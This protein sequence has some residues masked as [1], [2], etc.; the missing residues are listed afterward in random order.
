MT[1]HENISSPLATG[2]AGTTF[3]QHVGAMFLGLLLTRGIPPVFRDCQIDEV[4]FQT[5]HLGW[6]TDDLL[7]C[8][9]K[10]NGERH[11]L[12]IQVKRNLVVSSSSPD[13]EQT[14]QGFWDDFRTADLFDPERDA[15][16]LVTL[17]G[18][19]TLLDGLGSL[20][21]CARN[22][23][24]AADFHHKLATP[25]FISDKAR[26]YAEIIRSILDKID[27]LSPFTDGDFWRFL[28]AVYLL[29]C[30]FTTSTALQEASVRNVLAQAATGTNPVKAA[31]ATWHELVGIAAVSAS[32]ART[33]NRSD[34]PESMRDKH[35]T[36]Q[37]PKT[38]L[39]VLREHS[40]FTL[41]GIRSTIAETLTLP[42]NES[43]IRA[44]EALAVVQV[45]VLTGPP[46]SGKS[47]LA[48]AVAQWQA[49]D[50][51]CLSFRAEEFAESHIDNVLKGQ[52]TGT[53]L[54][55]LLAAQE[56]ILI[57]VESLERL[58]EHPTRDA[59]TDLIRMA[60]RCHN[61]RILL[62]CRDYALE[63]AVTS[64]IGQSGLTYRVIDLPPLDDVELSQVV[65][66][67]PELSIPLSN[68]R[69]RQLLRNPYFLDMAAR[70]VWTDAQGMPSDAITFRQRCW[71][72]VVRRDD[73]TTSGLPDRR[74]QAL[75]AL[76][77]RRARELRPSVL[78]EGIDA[79]ALDEL[80]KDGIVSRDVHGLVAPAHDVIED[81]A[82]IHWMESLSATYEWQ[83]SPII[84]AVGGYPALR[85]GFRGWLNEALE[86]DTDKADRF[87]LSVTNDS[88]LPQH[89]RDDVLTCMLLSPLARDFI[90]RQRDQLLANEASLLV[91]LIHLTR[92][93]CKTIP[94]WLSDSGTPPSIFLKPEGEAWSA[95]L[96]AVADGLGG[97]LPAHTGVIV[98]LIEDWSRGASWVEP[99]PAGAEPAG[100][101]AYGLLEQLDGYRYDDLR[102]R[103]LETIARVPRANEKAFISLVERA[104]NKAGR[105][106]PI[107]RAFAE[108]MLYGIDG[109]PACRDFPEQ[110]A[111]LTMS[112]CCLTNA[113]LK[114]MRG[115]YF[116]YIEPAFG[117]PAYLHLRF[118]PAS[119]FRGPFLQLLRHH[120]D[121]GVQLVLDLANHAGRWYGEQKW[122][123]FRLEPAR[124]ITI[125]V[126]G[127]GE[128]NQWANGRLW[129]SYRGTSVTPHVI[130]CALM[131][132]ETWLLELCEGTDD[133][134][135]WL[136]KIVLE[137][138]S[139]M[140][141]AVVA[142]VCNA[143][144]RRSGV[145][146]LALVASRE[147]VEMDR[148]RTVREPPS[149]ILMGISGPDPM[150]RFYT[151]ERK[152]SSALAHRSHDLEA[153]AWKLQLGGKAEQI[154]QIID[155]HRAGIAGENERT[156]ADRAWLLALHRMDMRNFESEV[157]IPSSEDED[158]GNGTDR[159]RTI[160]FKSK[161]IDTDLQGFV[162]A[163]A[164]ERD[165]FFAD[166]R[167]VSWGLQQ[168]E[169]RSDEW[170]PDAWQAALKQAK[171]V[172]SAGVPEAFVGLA[173][174]GLGLVAALYARDH[175]GALGPDDQRW[176]FDT[177]IAEVERDSDTEDSIKQVANDPMK[178]DRHSAY[179][180]PKFISKNPDNAPVLKAIAR[181]ITHACDQ[182]A[183]S[184]AEG[185]GEY[186]VP[187]SEDLMMRGVGALAMQANLLNR[188]NKHRT[189]SNSQSIE[190]QSAYS[191]AVQQV[192][193]QVRDAF[194]AGAINVETELK[195]LDLTSWTGMDA[196]VSIL[197]MLGKAPN[198]S[199]SRDFFV[200]AAQALVASWMTDHEERNSGRDFIRENAVMTRLVAVALALPPDAATYCCGPFLDA[201][202]DHPR[203][204]ATFVDL[205]IAQEERSSSDK[206][207]FWH[208]WQAFA[209]RVLDARWVSS[210]GS[211][212]S[213]GSDL[214]DKLLFRV[215]WKEGIRRWHRLDGHEHKVDGFTTH[216]PVAT[217]ILAAYASY[218]YTIGE[219][220]L[221]RAFMVVANQIET[222]DPNDLLSDGNTM[223]CLES[224]LR[225]YVY[226]QPL[227]LRTEPNLRKAVLAILD[228]LVDAG[229]AAAYRMRDDFVTPLSS[230]QGTR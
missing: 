215:G 161:G 110:M 92:V 111:R 93:A 187:E 116:P 1:Q 21:E 62:T 33:L 227:L 74:E 195:E 137:S 27:S 32:G 22:S 147:A 134:E 113:D 47:T 82:I 48:K 146:S 114:R 125:S 153:L 140:T 10:E 194:V 109:T 190:S 29:S 28:K 31:E 86:K 52:V 162:E 81:W 45:A 139:V 174:S 172:Q 120:P 121:V 164:E 189:P 193:D 112:W 95:V 73:L 58:L 65:K 66:A 67:L 129:E 3:E 87:V 103:V 130:E 96:E 138:N 41:Q 98:G 5:R 25:G 132:L 57:H 221:P 131:A 177:L 211:D 160:S 180:L 133:L 69:L 213:A 53:Q 167:L 119:A 199:L 54:E 80:H 77:V 152:R 173:D 127:H 89:S 7:V 83:A 226:G 203:E 166:A 191:S 100:K 149:S 126:P 123:G 197:A 85:R 42:R 35:G 135:P 150:Q 63:T 78:S 18:T 90:A 201:V 217:P 118:F 143:H 141:T 178:A 200:R 124:P 156:D 218:L 13:C 72:Q 229:S 171:E 70:M 91:R 170:D 155:A 208:V 168:W 50:H 55:T 15:L 105:R 136:V 122:P 106:D 175:W 205:L 108:I 84:E 210:I 2:G 26:N 157:L 16:L 204:V 186:L 20:L 8:C 188:L 179:V 61:V 75:C 184:A 49:N 107:A 165:R 144:P 94:R 60:E 142:S 76:A 225:R 128:V 11:R 79:L 176:C 196:S 223:F 68:P 219:G 9:S 23:S 46:G 97:L 38:A 169:R 115:D 39:K 206:S 59:F 104:S 185:A 117:L 34:L 207:S 228:H 30:D 43:L 222:G 102:K 224:L 182:V 154:S 159:S 209:D 64:F 158:P 192:R 71:G 145:S 181:A 183:L 216:L 12:A 163:G 19:N 198:T 202:E 44:N 56:R 24:D 4:S 99:L 37:S 214:V 40:D 212:Y 51:V 220:A 88:S 148:A 36:I 17:R 14:I 6:N 230:S 151:D 101:I